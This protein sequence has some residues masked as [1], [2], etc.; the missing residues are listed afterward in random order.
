MDTAFGAGYREESVHRTSDSLGEASIIN[1]FTGLQGALA[2]L[3]NPPIN[4]AI[5]LWELFG[6]TEVPILKNLPGAQALDGNFAVRYTDYSNGGGVTT[7]KTGLTDQVTDGFRLRTA[8]SYDVRAPNLVELF[9][10]PSSGFSSIA[11]PLNNNVRQSFTPV[12]VG[13]PNLK[14]E[15]SHTFTFGGVFQPSFLPGF[16]ASIDYW[17]IRLTNEITPIGAGTIVNQCYGVNNTKQISG[18]LP[19]YITRDPV[20]NLILRIVQP[21]SNLRVGRA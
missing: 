20:S 3:N 18:V 16:Y 19:E 21:T 12:T 5:H 17:N 7:W 1:A 15:D 10:P 4:G 11:D 14:P 2:Y 9:S 8:Y 13:N 6:E